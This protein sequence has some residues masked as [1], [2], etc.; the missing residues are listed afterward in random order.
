MIVIATLV[1]PKDERGLNL[2]LGN[3]LLLFVIVFLFYV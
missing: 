3:Q 1:M 2:H